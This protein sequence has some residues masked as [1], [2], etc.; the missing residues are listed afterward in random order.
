MTV[1]VLE[2][3]HFRKERSR[4]EISGTA[5]RPRLSIYR[6]L[7]HIYIQAIDDTQDKTLAFVSSLDPAIRSQIK[8]GGNIESAK[9]VGKLVAEK[10]LKLKIK[11]VVF[12]RG[13]RIFHGVIKAAADAAREGGLEF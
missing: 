9:M 8:S 6:S 4:K 1:S 11:K 2:R 13:G 12:D 5:D 3:Y 10:C 7:K